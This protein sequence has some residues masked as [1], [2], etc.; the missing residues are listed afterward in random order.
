MK[1]NKLKLKSVK[2]SK[3]IHE[4]RKVIQLRYNDDNDDDNNNIDNN[5]GE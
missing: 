4:N 1:A 5:K 3:Q 2:F